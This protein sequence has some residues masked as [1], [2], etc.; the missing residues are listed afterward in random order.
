MLP[1]CLIEECLGKLSLR[2]GFSESNHLT[3]EPPK[4]AQSEMQRR[5][6]RKGEMCL[7]V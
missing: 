3:E 7:R 4:L 2:K 6:A 5:G 1:R